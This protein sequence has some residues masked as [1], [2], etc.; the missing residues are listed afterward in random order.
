MPPG[1]PTLKSDWLDRSSGSDWLEDRSDWPKQPNPNQKLYF[2]TGYV[3]LLTF[4]GYRYPHPIFMKSHG[5]LRTTQSNLSKTHLLSFY[6]ILFTL[7]F[8]PRHAVLLSSPWRSR[9]PQLACRAQG[10]P[11]RVCPDGV[12]KTRL[13]GPNNFA[14]SFTVQVNINNPLLNFQ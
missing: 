10:K 5:R 4:I 9:T 14:Q 12:I 11:T 2:D 1:G 6:L 7:I 13:R 3:Q 8:Q